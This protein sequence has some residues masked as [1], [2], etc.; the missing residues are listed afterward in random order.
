LT[1]PVIALISIFSQ[2]QFNLGLKPTEIVLL[3]LTF[4]VSILTV[5]PGRAT[6]LQSVIHLSIF[7]SFLMFAAT[8]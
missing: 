8:P 5:A 3:S 1:I 4:L 6:L 7:G 2:Y